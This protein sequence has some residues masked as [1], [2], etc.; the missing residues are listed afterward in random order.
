MR[1]T[2]VEDKIHDAWMHYCSSVGRNNS[3]RILIAFSGGSDSTALLVA[4]KNL[5]NRGI[6]Q[7]KLGAV[8]VRH[9]IRPESQ[10]ASEE[11]FV[12]Q[13]AVQLSVPL[14]ILEGLKKHR[15]GHGIEEEA[16][17]YR[18]TLLDRIQGNKFQ[19]NKIQGNKIQGSQ[20]WDVI[21][22]GHHLQDDVETMIQQ[23][24]R[25][26]GYRSNAGIPPE[27]GVYYRPLLGIEPEELKTYLQSQSITWM[28]DLSNLDT[29]ISRNDIRHTLL[30]ELKKHNRNI[31]SH[32]MNGKKKTRLLMDFIEA[33]I[34]TI[35]WQKGRDNSLTCDGSL[36]L[37]VHP[38][39]RYE[40]LLRA[41]ELL[42]S[43]EYSFPGLE[44]FTDYYSPRR[45]RYNR[46]SLAFFEPLLSA[47]VQ[48]PMR[49]QGSGLCIH[50]DTEKIVL[51]PELVLS[52]KYGYCYTVRPGLRL[53]V[54]GGWFICTPVGTEQP[55]YKLLFWDGSP[56]LVCRSVR[57]QEDLRSLVSKKNWKNYSNLM[58]NT[59]RSGTIMSI[60]EA[61]GIPLQVFFPTEDSWI[62]I[63]TTA[64]PKDQ[65]FPLTEESLV[66]GLQSTME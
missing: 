15:T 29:S 1:S 52:A 11:R 46:I 14:I 8:Y 55:M 6:L 32:L 13:T 31:V 59:Q 5:F 21:A 41:L 44:R 12:I 49:I 62:V 57:E 60:L 58:E 65:Q 26:A 4:T 39:I 16:R 17:D 42:K 30:P 51:S 36:F 48:L 61:N 25:G 54:E 24:V 28:E 45:A 3:L 38:F 40:A 43:A 7:G 33:T 47:K 50:W 9:K 35:P 20:D 63:H 23:F 2:L 56:G 27:R 10:T 22:T 66:C 64:F 34:Q 37:S 18:Y 53:P 19:G